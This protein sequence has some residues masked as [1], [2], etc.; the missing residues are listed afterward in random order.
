M[1]SRIA[2][3]EEVYAEFDL[4]HTF[5]KGPVPV[6]NTIAEIKGSKWPEQVVIV[7]GHLDSWDGPGSQG[8][9]DNGTGTVVTLEAA[10]ILAAVHAKPLRTIRFIDWTGEE[11]GL[12][13]SKA[14]VEAHK[15]EMDNISAVLV[16][17]GGTNSEGGLT[18]A[19]PMVEMMA[20]A[21]APTNNQFYDDVDK[22]Y[23]NVNIKH[24]GEKIRTHGASDHASFNQVHVPGFFWD[25]VGRDDYTHIHH[26]QFDRIDDAIPN[27]LVQS[28]T[29]AAIT[30]YRLACAPSLLPREVPPPPPKEEKKDEKQ[31]ERGEVTLPGWLNVA[32]DATEAWLPPSPPSPSPRPV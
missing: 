4:H 9:G 30:A 28:A 20:A 19:D 11:Q 5:N 12:L 7:S 3:G 6:Y 32:I 27:Y 23:L 31:S 10:R 8:A 13:G 15:A 14:Y 24:G 26:T 1:N 16:D 25:E 18:V 29:N 17:D 2:D 21:T 22:R